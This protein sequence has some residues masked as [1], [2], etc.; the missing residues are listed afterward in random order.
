VLRNRFLRFALFGIALVTAGRPAFASRLIAPLWDVWV[1]DESGKPVVGLGVTVQHEDFGCEHKDHVE[2]QFTDLQ[3]HVQFQPRYLNTAFKCA[4]ITTEKLILFNKNRHRHARVY[5]GDTDHELAG[6]DVDKSGR[7]V[8]WTG[9]PEHMKSHIVVHPKKPAT[10]TASNP[11]V[12]PPTN[13]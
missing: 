12:N 7:P 3:G 1:V 10:S 8:E 6:R 11:P 13:P 5:A 9:N 2:T 4:T